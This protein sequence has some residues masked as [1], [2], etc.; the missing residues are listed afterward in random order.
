[1]NMK[2]RS[3]SVIYGKAEKGK[4]ILFDTKDFR[5]KGKGFRWEGNGFM[6]LW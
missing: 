6:S 3:N 1:M 2:S 5:L 4:K